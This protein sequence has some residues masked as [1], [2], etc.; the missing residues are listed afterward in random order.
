[1]HSEDATRPLLELRLPKFLQLGAG[2]TRVKARTIRATPAV[3]AA[4]AEQERI[5]R[6]RDAEV[7]AAAGRLAELS[8]R[9]MGY[10]NLGVAV[11]RLCPGELRGLP[12]LSARRGGVAWTSKT[13][14][15]LYR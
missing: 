5:V 1:M 3:E 6:E 15:F 11:T 2:D 4:L 10:G 14:P 13:E 9:I 7:S 12:R 8:R